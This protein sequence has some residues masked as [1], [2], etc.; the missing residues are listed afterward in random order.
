MSFRKTL[1]A[2]AR[3]SNSTKLLKKHSSEHVIIRNLFT[4]KTNQYQEK[5]GLNKYVFL[6]NTWANKN[7]VKLAVEKMFDTQVDWVNI[8]TFP[9]KHKERRTTRFYGKKAI[10]TLKKDAKIDFFMW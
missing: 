9:A 1:Q 4:E 5:L 10:V 7:D 3:K 6:V 2:R 8:I